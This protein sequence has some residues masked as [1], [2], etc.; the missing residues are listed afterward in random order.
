MERRALVQI[1]RDD[2]D[3]LRFLSEG[4]FAE[5]DT[6]TGEI[7]YTD[8]GD[9]LCRFGLDNYAR[10]YPELG[11]SLTCVR[12]AFDWPDEIKP[13]TEAEKRRYIPLDDLVTGRV[14]Y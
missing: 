7:R 3:L 9:N 6:L 1:L 5:Y 14:F 8:P 13:R 11:G 2:P 4:C 10:Q 12:N